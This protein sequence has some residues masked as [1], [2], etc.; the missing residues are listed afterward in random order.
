MVITSLKTDFI[1]SVHVRKLLIVSAEVHWRYLSPV[2]P[3][4]PV[5]LRCED[6][7]WLVG[8]A[9]PL[10]ECGADRIGEA[11]RGSG[12]KWGSKGSPSRQAPCGSLRVCEAFQATWAERPAGSDIRG[13]RRRGEEREDAEEEENEQEGVRCDDGLDNTVV[14]KIENRHTHTH[15]DTI[16]VI[17]VITCVR[18]P[19][20]VVSQQNLVLHAGTPAVGALLL[21]RGCQWG[22]NVRT[23]YMSQKSHDG[24]QLYILLLYIHQMINLIRLDWK[25]HFLG[26]WAEI[27]W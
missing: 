7:S 16:L 12:G 10:G 25:S 18:F 19:P 11:A 26:I 21:L 8:G 22:N 24:S 1:C 17:S 14:C 2:G 20:E 4:L 9:W 27:C 23:N 3:C 5:D 13:G 15:T 6:V